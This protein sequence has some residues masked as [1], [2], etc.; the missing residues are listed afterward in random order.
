MVCSLKDLEK[1]DAAMILIKCT[2]DKPIIYNSY[3]RVASEEDILK[4]T[5]NDLLDNI[6]ICE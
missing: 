5:M 2:I 6:I 4:G 3:K 1:T